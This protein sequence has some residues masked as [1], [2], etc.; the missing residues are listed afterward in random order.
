MHVRLQEAAGPVAT[1]TDLLAG[2]AAARPE[3]PAVL[4]PGRTP[5]TYGA[6]HRLVRDQG[7]SLR[8]WGIGRQD[9]VA[10]AL[11]DGYDTAVCALV[12]AANAVCASFNPLLREPEL[13]ALLERARPRAVVVQTEDGA[14]HRAARSLGI[15]VLTV[16]DEPWT[17]RP[18]TPMGPG[19]RPVDDSPATAED[20]ALILATSGTTGGTKL[21]PLT[22]RN[23]LAGASATVAAHGLTESDRRLNFMPL[24]HVQGLVGSLTSTLVA[25]SGIICT[26]GFEAARVPGW[27]R[28]WG[29]TW[30]S[31]TP[32]MHTE[33]L[34]V[35]GDVV[36]DLGDAGLRFLRAGSAALPAALRVRLE[37]AFGL[38]VVESYGMTEAHQIASTSLWPGEHK[39]GTVGRPTGS[40]VAVV[41]QDGSGVA[42]PGEVGEVVLRGDNVFGGYLDAPEANRAAFTDGWFRTGDLGLLD[43]DGYVVLRGRLKELINRGGE[44]VSPREID[45]VLLAHPAVS[46]AVAFPVPDPRLQE[47]IGVAVVLAD[48]ARLDEQELR[49]FASGRL[50]PFKVPRHVVFVDSVPRTAGGKIRR[51]DLAETMGVT[52]MTNETTGEAPDIAA[53][54]VETA[55]AGLWQKA[56]GLPEVGLDDDFFFLGGDSLTGAQVLQMVVDVF[57]VELS[58]FAMYDEANT[59]RTMA[60]LI[61]RGRTGSR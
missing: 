35:S 5:L 43:E 38:P 27:V 40:Q 12:V 33:I 61:Q 19:G 23:V 32:T 53:T 18:L 39:P 34:R 7:A 9:R 16:S 49:R 6:L 59:V 31:A 52:T 20:T 42:A 24:Y 15:A 13:R 21:V 14:A 26:R 17:L 11:A 44:K 29:A 4:G 41:R 57:G 30:Y 47:D 2:H 37:D 8:E 10:L 3:T 58:S 46:E 51:L 25:G 60:A 45:E 55:V 54:A 48:G 22:H 50:A 56:L 36:A 28:E 1:V